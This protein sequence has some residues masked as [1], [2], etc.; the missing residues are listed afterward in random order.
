MDRFHMA[1]LSVGRPKAQ[2]RGRPMDPDEEAAYV[3]E[4]VGA[5]DAVLRSSLDAAERGLPFVGETGGVGPGG[6]AGSG[7]AAPRG[8]RPQRQVADLATIS[9]EIAEARRRAATHREHEGP[10][11]PRP[12]KMQR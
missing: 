4:V 2:V 5:K 8:G 1:W 10:R 6:A 7:G 3:R 11:A 12:E 9:E